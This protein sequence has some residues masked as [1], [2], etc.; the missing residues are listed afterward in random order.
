MGELEGLSVIKFLE[1][2]RLPENW[3]SF[4]VITPQDYNIALSAIPVGNSTD[5]ERIARSADI[6][7]PDR[8]PH[9]CYLGVDRAFDSAVAQF[10]AYE[11]KHPRK[12]RGIRTLV[13]LPS[14]EERTYKR[15]FKALGEAN[16]AYS[17]L[18]LSHRLKV[19]EWYQKSH[20]QFRTDRVLES[21]Y[22]Q[23]ARGGGRTGVFG[24][25][26]AS[27]RNVLLAMGVSETSIPSEREL[28]NHMT[29]SSSPTAEGY[30]RIA[31]VGGVAKTFEHNALQ[32]EP[33]YSIDRLID[34]V[35]EEAVAAYT[36]AGHACAIS[37]IVGDG[38]GI[39]FVVHDPLDIQDP[40]KA[41]T[42][43][44][45]LP[46]SEVAQTLPGSSKP[47]DIVQAILVRPTRR[48]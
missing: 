24:C 7:E 14:H 6:P 31:Q 30:L 23:R 22:F 8:S 33:V 18:L 44:R 47:N 28:I 15:M 1:T 26:P 41:K 43:A 25:V 34:G 40:L 46:I 20:P 5:L 37:G 9:L 4:P 29:E 42:P 39:F 21:G 35:V 45:L 32:A 10:N 2:P 11:R 13:R 3:Q 17:A 16:R 27:T 19:L 36:L 38:S 12:I 48:F